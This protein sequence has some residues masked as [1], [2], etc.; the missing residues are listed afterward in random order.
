M[1][2]KLRVK[3]GN[4]E[5]RVEGSAEVIEKEREAFYAGIFTKRETAKMTTRLFD[6]Y[7]AQETTGMVITRMVEETVSWKVIE[8]DIK[9]HSEIFKVGDIVRTI[10][11]NGDI[12][13][14]AIAEITDDYVRFDARDCVGEEYC[15]ND[16]GY[17]SGG[18]AD[19]DM[20]AH[21][22]DKIWNLL[23]EDLKEVISETV[24]KYADDTETKEY[25]T[26]LFLADASEVFDPD[27]CYGEKGLYEQLEYYKNR[28]NRV[29]LDS[30]M[31]GSAAWWLSSPYVGNATSFC[32]VSAAGAAINSHASFAYGVAPC[33]IINRS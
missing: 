2:N 12:A 24:R 19:S 5:L 6:Q 7:N 29:K 9:N 28:H 22:D 10:L 17:N 15:M 31:G 26:K 30:Y 11:T 1:S 27:N 18:V 3:V 32:G 33:F 8:D 4:K 25:K 14:W 23:P 13:E 16:N 21:L 20:Q